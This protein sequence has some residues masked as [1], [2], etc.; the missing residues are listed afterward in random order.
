[1]AEIDLCHTRGEADHVDRRRAIVG[2][3]ITQLA[4]VV[5]TPTLHSPGRG[6]STTVL[7]SGIDLHHATRESADDHRRVLRACRGITQLTA[8]VVAPTQDPAAGLQCAGVVIAGGNHRDARR[9]SDGFGWCVAAFVRAVA[10]LTPVVVAP[11]TYAARARES[12]RRVVARTHLDVLGVGHGNPRIGPHRRLRGRCRDT[13]LDVGGSRPDDRDRASR[14]IDRY[15]RRVGAGVNDVVRSIRRRIGVRDAG[16]THT[17]AARRQCDG[18]EL[19]LGFGNDGRLHTRHTDWNVTRR[20]GLVAQL[21][22][23]VVAPTPHVALRRDGTRRVVARGDRTHPGRQTRHRG[24]HRGIPGVSGRELAVAVPTPALGRARRESRAEVL[25]SAVDFDRVRRPRDR[26]RGVG[27]VGR[28]VAVL[29]VRAVAPAHHLAAT[30]DGARRVRRRCH[31]HRTGRETENVDRRVALCR[32]AVAEVAPRVVAP[33]LRSSV[34]HRHAVVVL[35]PVDVDHAARQSGHRDRHVRI[36]RVS[37]T[38]FT[39][40]A[41]APARHTAGRENGAARVARS[42]NVDRVGDSLHRHRDG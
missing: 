15:D 39:V 34:D 37:A 11:A 22:F 9:Q 18:R 29:P 38:E 26:H 4:V 24:R 14:R 16:V 23:G 20:T 7:V 42:S 41:V 5:Q 21:I 36:D 8:R 28:A 40:T 30:D 32:R 2:G 33:T 10:Q 13:R 19:G 1:M 17:E 27:L 12:A 6:E 3:A 31:A 25:M 35:R